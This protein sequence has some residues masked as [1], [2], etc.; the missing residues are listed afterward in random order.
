MAVGRKGNRV[1][2]DDVEGRETG[3][4]VTA[5]RGV[6]GGFLLAARIVMLIVAVIVGIIVAGILLKVLG[7]NMGNSLV[8]AV[9]DV[10]K[11]LVG[12]FED[13]F[14]IKD[15]KVSIAVNWGIAA[16]IYAI[17]GTLIA[18]LLRVVGVKSH[19]DRVG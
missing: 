11:A 7:A 13:L 3:G 19:P 4:A 14:K 15:P 12:P 18:R 1:E 8:K 2:D 9:T 16:A 17:V 5:R 6:G 10:A